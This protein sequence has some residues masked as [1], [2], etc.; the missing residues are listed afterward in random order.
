MLLGSRQ[1]ATA[2]VAINSREDW[3]L[4]T[5][6]LLFSRTQG[7]QNQ[8]RDLKLSWQEVCFNLAIREI[9]VLSYV[10]GV[11]GK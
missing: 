5:P 2:S 3:Q 1:V 8:P 6:W 10:K 4:T 7:P 11:T 9:T